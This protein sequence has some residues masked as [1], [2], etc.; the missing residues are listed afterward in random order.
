MKATVPLA[1]EATG[2]SVLKKCLQ[3]GTGSRFRKLR[4][5]FAA[6]DRAGEGKGAEIGLALQ[7]IRQKL[8]IDPPRYL[9][10]AEGTQMLRNELRVEKAEAS[11]LEPRDEMHQ[12]DFRG[13]A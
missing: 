1:L 11:G 10:C 6:G 3:F 9:N 4:Q 12:R 2:Q 8:L 13:V 7:G 5:S